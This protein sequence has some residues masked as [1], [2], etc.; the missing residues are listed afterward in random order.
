MNI[1][2][3]IIVICIALITFLSSTAQTSK[4]LPKEDD[5]YKIVTLP[6]PEDMLL[7]VGG[8]TTLPD[9]R[10]AVCT[11]RGD[12]WI[13]DVNAYSPRVD[14]HLRQHLDAGGLSGSRR[15]P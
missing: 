3:R 1:M 2:K 14:D 11:R 12:V 6:S 9:G 5:Y 15:S 8:V 13:V 7:E 4:P 10:I